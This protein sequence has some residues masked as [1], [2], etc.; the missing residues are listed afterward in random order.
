[1]GRGQ[2]N[3][4]QTSLL[5]NSTPGNLFSSECREIRRRSGGKRDVVSRAERLRPSKVAGRSG[6]PIAESGRDN[7]MAG[8]GKMGWESKE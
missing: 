7:G 2:S 1:M 5:L 3:R 6:R 8:A 4:S